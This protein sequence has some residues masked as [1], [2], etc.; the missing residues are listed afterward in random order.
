[1]K[2]LVGNYAEFVD[3]CAPHS[4][5]RGT[6]SWSWLLEQLKDN[7][8]VVPS[9]VTKALGLSSGITFSVLAEQCLGRTGNSI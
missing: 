5:A 8:D 7:D 9:E 1:M 2:A 6:D 3:A 4:G